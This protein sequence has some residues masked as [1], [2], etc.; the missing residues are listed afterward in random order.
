VWLKPRFDKK[1]RAQDYAD[2]K[3]REAERRGITVDKMAPAKPKATGETCDQWHE[4]YLLLCKEQGITD[5]QDEGGALGQVDRPE[6]RTQGTGRRHAR[7]RGRRARQ[8]GRC[9]SGLRH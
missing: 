3:A 5:D 2:D 1:E 9:D 7:Q 8:A 4:R 6:A